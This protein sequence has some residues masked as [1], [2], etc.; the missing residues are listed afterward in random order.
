M[1][2]VRIKNILKTLLFVMAF[3]LLLPTAAAAEE[4][5]AQYSLIQADVRLPDL[6]LY[7]AAKDDQS[8]DSDK[9][10]ITLKSGKGK[11]LIQSVKAA[12]E[13][14][15]GII[16]Y[17]LFDISTSVSEEQFASMKQSLI[18]LSDEI[19]KNDK[20]KVITF[21]KEVKT[22]SDGSEEKKEFQSI[23]NNLSQEKKTH[24]YEGIT[25]AAAKITEDKKE[26]IREEKE[27]RQL[28]IILT[29]WQEVKDAGGKESKEE[30]LKAMQKT[31]VP[32]FG[33]CL[34]SASVSLQDDMG[35]FLRSTGGSFKRYFSTEDVKED[36]LV[37]FHQGRLKDYKIS[38]A[39][40]FAET[41][42]SADVL[43]A[44]IDGNVLVKEDIYLNFAKAD[45]TAPSITAVEEDGD[46]KDT[47]ILTF[48]EAVKNADNKNNY[49][50]IRGE[51]DS[52]PVLE[53]TYAE[54]DGEYKVTLVFNEPLS[55]GKYTISTTNI[56]DCSD[57]HNKIEEKWS[58]DLNG[59]GTAKQI[60]AF[61]GKI[62]P[63]L[64]FV[65]IAVIL[66]V[67][68]FVIKKNKGI[69]VVDDDIIVGNN[70][71]SKQHIKQD[72]SITKHIVIDVEGIGG[73]KK[74]IKSQVVSSLIVGR[75]NICDIFFDD[76]NMSKQ[77]F[78]IVIENSQVFIKDLE[79]KNGTFVN[80]KPVEDM[81]QIQ[82]GDTV[83]A[84]SVFMTMRW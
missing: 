50:V 11:C 58:G 51:K 19:R 13:E 15:T 53:A 48:S 32:L 54:E 81:V 61:L 35:A 25:E 28:A 62:W 41:S 31:G 59:Q 37:Q 38:A 71:G 44:D 14:D 39:F 77:H 67:I 21:G 84:G 42:E 82:S 79:S 70:V 78:A 56:T 17:V 10:N 34:D 1:G 5:D 16:Y 27:S 80:D 43:E 36:I 83:R 63:V 74:S 65:A 72:D 49:T 30:A 6:K 33:Y 22:V 55:K 47:L 40:T 26:Q 68:Y 46:K 23:I 75:S 8:F 20:I 52:C 4:K 76:L 45:E 24:L 3:L 12:E 57:A 18:N 2:S 9:V 73:S 64:V 66:L 69:M 60:F 7:V 29:D